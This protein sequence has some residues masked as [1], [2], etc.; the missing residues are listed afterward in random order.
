MPLILGIIV[1]LLVI[2]FVIFYAW[3]S[4]GSLPN[5]KLSEIVSF[6]PVQPQTGGNPH[7][8]VFVLMSYNLGYLSGMTNNLP[9]TREKT[10]FDKN[11]SAVLALLNNLKPD[12]LAFQEIDFNAKRSYYVNQFQTIGE[13]AGYSYGASAVNWDKRYVP[14]PYWPP[15]IHFGKVVSGQAV[16]STWPILTTERKVLQKR[17]DKPFYYNAFYLQRLVQ[18]TKIQ[19]VEKELV[20]LNLHLEALDR[21]TR[22]V[23][24]HTVLDI[25]RSYKDDYPVLI[26][27]DFNS[28][29]PTAEQKKD[30]KDE[31]ETDFTGDETISLFLQEKSLQA[32][33]LSKFT[34]PSDKPT[35]KLDYIFYNHAKIELIKI[36][37]VEMN[38]SDHLPLIM[39]FSFKD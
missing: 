7:G 26:V 33:E 8:D 3:A 14:F 28:V 27:G 30:F 20:L 24:A 22:E 21:E 12:I 18:I 31:P 32:A 23:Q 34:F 11:M 25:Y 1:A 39:E 9:V 15:S 35:R 10:L 13:N 36:Y 38:S 2:S 29:P 6:S 37:T 19:T 16:L 4:S 5:N 17:K